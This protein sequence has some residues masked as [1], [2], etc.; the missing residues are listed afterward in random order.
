[1]THHTDTADPERGAAAL[2][3]VPPQGHV[4]IVGCGP[5]GCYTALALRRL[6]PEVHITVFDGRI[7]P[8]GLV[9]YGVAPDHQGM[10]NISKQ[11]DRLFASNNVDFVGNTVVGVDLPTSAV[12]ANFDVIVIATGL[13]HDRPLAVP[14]DPQARVYGA[15]QLLRLLN[16]DPDSHLRSAGYPDPLGQDVVIIGAGNVA[17]D[18]ARLLCK[19]DE[20]F[21]GSDVDDD[22]R[23]ALQASALRRLTLLA[24]GPRATARWDGA[25]FAELC[26][27]P[28]ISVC[29]DGEVDRR[30]AA[31]ADTA[32]RERP[33][34][35]DIRFNET[36]VG[37][38]ADDQY[39]I[40]RTRATSSHAGAQ[41][42]ARPQEFAHRADTVVTA[43]GFIDTP[44][45]CEWTGENRVVRVG[46]CSSGNLGNL[47]ENRTL[48]KTAA[49][50]VVGL[51]QH[52]RRGSLGLA[53][54]RDHLPTAATT[55]DDWSSIDRAES[56]QAR[57][58]RVRT[59]FTSWSAMADVIADHRGAAARSTPGQTQ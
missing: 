45:G 4:A 54:I 36:P 14:V 17:M 18:V 7:T 21:R 41:S 48:A 49:Q 35:V 37:V 40:V 30:S 34:Q 58:D 27:L 56:A 39:C 12:E 50:R 31:A 42:A 9:R 20:G 8:F 16:G 5:S 32:V 55:F 3:H 51:L 11:F 1:M 44:D 15:G 29:V 6:A 59:K 22:A 19:T 52:Q 28:H 10:K 13:A 23:I 33:I 24:R 2:K 57:P 46:G 43:M 25:M 47:A 53:G 26:S 38:D